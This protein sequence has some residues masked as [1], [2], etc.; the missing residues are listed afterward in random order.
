[1][2]PL[3]KVIKQK[4]IPALFNDFQI[5]E[6]LRSWIVLPCKLGGMGIINPME[7]KNEEYVNSHELTKELTNLIMQQEHSYTVGR[8]NK[9]KRRSITQKKQR[10]K[11]QRNLSLL[12]EKMSYMEI[13]LNDI[14]QEQ[15]SFSWLTVLPI[16]R[17][18]FNLLKSD[19]WDAVRLRNGL[20]LKRLSSHCGWSKPYNIQQVLSRN[21]DA[22][23]PTH[24]ELID[25]IT[26]MPEEVTSIVKAKPALQPF[27]I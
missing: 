18:G 3:T 22:L 14:A 19:F 6:E 24:S 5:S 12:R 23:A 27:W 21:K 26:E 17:I 15:G 4:L 1:M 2:L 11:Q 10:G 9:K 8:W 13:R 25:N 16:K 20:P 7:I